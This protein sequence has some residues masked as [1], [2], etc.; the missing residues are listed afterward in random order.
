MKK[1][2]IFGILNIFL[3][4]FIFCVPISF[5]LNIESSRPTMS[6]TLDKFHEV[7][8][9]VK[10]LVLENDEPQQPIPLE[11]NDQVLLTLT[12]IKEHPGEADFQ[13]F[14]D[15]SPGSE[16]TMKLV[17]GD[18]RIVGQYILNE[19]VIIPERT[20]TY[21]KG[22][23]GG[24]EQTG[25]SFAGSA[26]M[27]GVMAAALGLGPPGWIAAGVLGAV[28]LITTLAGDEC[29]GKEEDVVIE[30]VKFDSP[31][32]GGV[33]GNITLSNNIYSKNKITFYTFAMP[34][35][36]ILEDM[37]ILGIIENITTQN[38]YRIQPRLS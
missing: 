13:Q 23:T 1:N 37:N 38:I 29:L 8:V 27:T 7:T 31:P 3:M 10:K 2:N 30:E 20:D 17:P 35:P 14:A 18:Y 36:E 21:C 33:E 16:I 11:S 25:S 12:K 5:S 15:Y 6:I 19:E 4:I 22:P 24:W 26:A 34:P 9:E 32:L 28:A